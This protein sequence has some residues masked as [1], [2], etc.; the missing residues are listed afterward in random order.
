[1][2]EQ[3]DSV[4]RLTEQLTFS[5]W[6]LLVAAVLTMAVVSPYQYVWSS[7]QGPLAAH[8]GVR[9]QALGLAFSLFVL[10]QAGTQFPVGLWRDRHGP[11]G[12]TAIAAVLAGGSYVGLSY[13]SAAWHVYVL[14]FT[15]AIGVGIV[16]TVAV[17][18]AVKWFPDRRGLTT[19]AG[20]MAFAGGSV[21]FVPYVRANASLTAV[22]STLRNMGILI[23][24]VI[25]VAAFVLRDPPM[26]AS[27][28]DD[29]TQTD[30]GTSRSV[31]GGVDWRAMVRTW[32]FWLMYVIFVAVSGAGLMLTAQVI[33]FAESLDLPATTATLSATLLPLAG[34]VGRLTLGDL[35]DRVRRERA[36]FASF[37]CCGLG[38]LAVVW[39]ARTGN[40]LGFVAAV[41]VA[42]FFWSPQYTLF[43]S[44]VGDYYGEVHSSGNYALV[45]SGKVWGGLF[46]GAAVGWLVSV[47]GWQFAFAVGGLLAVGGGLASL[48]L[49]P[50]SL[51]DGTE[52][53]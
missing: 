40:G 41:V 50:P 47:T 27:D 18:T 4:Q 51:A 9:E 52:T 17:N 8:I 42:T 19:G 43:P 37:L 10:G 16:Y 33:A 29:G 45:Y 2:G 20:T 36:M 46:G 11:R 23:G 15:G 6:W 5:R 31:S 25:L 26:S 48:A 21:M 14:Y 1:M 53:D 34:G 30:G 12:L 24:V 49:R 3:R 22:P 44:L 7:L 39:F 32:Q 13:A 35:S 38:L 28:S